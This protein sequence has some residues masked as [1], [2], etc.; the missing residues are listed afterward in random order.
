MFLLCQQLYTLLYNN[1]ISFMHKLRMLKKKRKEKESVCRF[2]SSSVCLE[3]SVWKGFVL[4]RM[5]L[6]FYLG[7]NK[8]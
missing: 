6:D 4:L 3:G 7:V 2:G 1:I 8:R 5:C